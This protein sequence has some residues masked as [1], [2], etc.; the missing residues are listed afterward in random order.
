MAK[1]PW[2][3]IIPE[4]ELAIYK[5]A[6]FG[7]SS[8]LGK[9]PALLIIDMQYRSM[10]E[11]PKPILQAMDEYGPSCGEHGWRAVPN[12][13][14]LIAAFRERGFPV[15]YP[16]VAP[17]TQHHVGSFTAKIPGLMSV[18]QR[19]YEFVKDI[20]PLPTD[21]LLPK[22]Q[23]SAFFGTPL[24]TH[25][26]QNRCDSVVVVGC[27]TSGC[28]RGT[29]V[30]ANGFNF[31]VVVPEDAVYDRSQVSHAVNLFDMAHKYADVAPTADVL[32]MLPPG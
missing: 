27:T 31:K 22:N 4:E 7:G 14:K 18:P 29:A 12:V 28:V 10:G 17:K 32:A 25:L 5:K 1:R 3:G 21:L 15:M 20:A 19:G 11:S 13:V 6:G 8:G 23:A 2:D 9:R 26:I 30:D 16:Y 24:I